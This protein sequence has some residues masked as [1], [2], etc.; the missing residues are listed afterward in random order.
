MKD[1]ARESSIA[2]R[3]VVFAPAVIV[4]HDIQALAAISQQLFAT[5]VTDW[6]NDVVVVGQFTVNASGWDDCC[7]HV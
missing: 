5:V 4:S 1:H 2:F 7:T 6:V 3:I